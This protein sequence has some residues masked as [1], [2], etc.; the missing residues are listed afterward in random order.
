M[1][2]IFKDGSA[3]CHDFNRDAIAGEYE[4]EIDP[5]L[6][7]VGANPALYQNNNGV[8]EPRP[9]AEREAFEAEEALK[10]EKIRIAAE[11]Y[12]MECADLL[13]DGRVW[14][15]GREDR[16]LMFQAY[17]AI[18]SGAVP[19]QRWKCKDGYYDMTPAN[20]GALYA[21]VMNQVQTAFAWEEA[22]L[23]LM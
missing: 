2:A 14:R 23:S 7:S 18:T 3:I 15:M 17:Y 12:A 21:A 4:V 10:A 20:I 22:Q 5:S 1:K 16:E 11:R 13:H 9:L 19:S 6:L 8:F